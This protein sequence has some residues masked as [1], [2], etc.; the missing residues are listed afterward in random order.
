MSSVGAVADG[1]RKEMFQCI[2]PGVSQAVAVGASSV[3]AS[4]FSDGVTIIRVFCTVDAWISFGSSPTAAIEG[5]SSMFLPGGI[6][7]Y[8]E[9][10]NGEKLAVI[11]NTA[12][13]KLYITEGATS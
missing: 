1:F 9:I 2:S 13:G 12:S 8:F 5:A 3:Q 11:R 6:L 7:E 4:S 10:K